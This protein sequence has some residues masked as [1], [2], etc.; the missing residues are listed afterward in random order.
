MSGDSDKRGGGVE[1]TVSP[2]VVD[3]R[4]AHHGRRLTLLPRSCVPRPA[5]PCRAS[6]RKN[7]EA[8]HF[9]MVKFGSR[10]VTPDFMCFR[11]VRVS[12]C[13]VCSVSF[14]CCVE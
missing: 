8:P 14:L 4:A 1:R 9:S 2:R 13:Y 6:L 7:L 10:D 11:F 5:P 12:L 3:R